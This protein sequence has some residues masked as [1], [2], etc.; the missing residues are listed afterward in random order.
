M[1]KLQLTWTPIKWKTFD[2]IVTFLQFDEKVWPLQ[3]WHLFQRIC[4]FK[5]SVCPWGRK[6]CV[7]ECVCV[8]KRVR[9]REKS[10][11]AIFFY[12]SLCGN[13]DQLIHSIMV[14]LLNS[15]WKNDSIY[16][17]RMQRKTLSN[18]FQ[19]KRKIILRA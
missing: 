8:W 14:L 2:V 4:N 10:D 18:V 16:L 9:E 19:D 7:C 11:C 15:L 12:L 6:T 3:N 5:Y 13:C 17:K 1:T